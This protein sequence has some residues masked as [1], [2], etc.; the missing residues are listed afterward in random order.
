[1]ELLLG[2]AAALLASLLFNAGLVLQA[3]EARREPPSLALRLQ[4]VLVLVRR[5]RWSLGLLLG[6]V[7]V[8][9]QVVA[10]AL[11]PFVI[12]Q[13]ALTVGLLLVLAAGT[14]TL[15]ERVGL[16][17]WLGVVAIVVGVAL[18][19]LGAPEHAETHRGGATVLLVV[20][21]PTAIALVPFVVRG[22]RADTGTLTMIAAGAGF[23][24]TNIAT[25]LMSDDVGLGHY[26]NAAA[27]AAVGLALGV[28]ATITGMTAFQR[29][30][31]TV[32]VPVTTAIQTFVP[33]V[34]EPLFLR[35]QWPSAPLN[36][37]VL[38]A[39]L[40]VACIGTVAVARAPGVGAVVAA[41][42][43]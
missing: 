6:L 22:T 1:M 26:A 16:T 33:V 12:V 28:A 29:V 19:A 32:A 7:G 42:S 34:L 36:G 13:P 38:A 8:V 30:P 37:A 41:T 15:G 10:L 23:A 9:P 31:A 35:E 40:V 11:A 5:W 25:K 2:L 18:V 14:R 3:L 21:V 4:L 27:W 43:A 24:A 39:G 20:A 17:V